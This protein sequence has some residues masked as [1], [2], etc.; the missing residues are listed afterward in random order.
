ML[1]TPVRPWSPRPPRLTCSRMARERAAPGAARAPKLA[2]FSQLF[3]LVLPPPALSHGRGAAAQPGD[4][5]RAAGSGCPSPARSAGK[6]RLHLQRTELGRGPGRAPRL[7]GTHQRPAAPRQLASRPVP[8]PAPQRSS[9]GS[10]GLPTG[11][12]SSG[13]GFELLRPPSS[14]TSWKHPHNPNRHAQ[15]K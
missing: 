3:L 14:R 6:G 2:A 7:L 11:L 1:P 4:G 10:G 13:R 5:G 8:F 12:A 9:L 15:N